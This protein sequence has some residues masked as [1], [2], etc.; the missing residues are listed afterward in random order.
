MCIL[1]VMFLCVGKG[2]VIKEADVGGMIGMRMCELTKG[3]GMQWV[4]EVQ[5]GKRKERE[6]QRRKVTALGARTLILLLAVSY[7][8]MTYN[9][10]TD[11]TQEKRTAT[12]MRVTASRLE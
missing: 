11:N 3:D 4:M 12:R 7:S 6:H 1:I 10:C 2:G 9:G 8:H 5:S